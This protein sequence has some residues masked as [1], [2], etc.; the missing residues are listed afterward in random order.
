M[1]R[2]YLSS[3]YADLV[4]PR[5]GVYRA[6]RRLGHDVIAMEDYGA[7]DER[8]A[9]KCV[10]DAA[11]ADIYVGI[12]AWRYGYLPPGETRS[13]TELEFRAAR[14]AGK[15]CLL[16]LLHEDAPWPRSLVDRN[17]EAIE[18]LRAE[19][20]RDFT[21]A[22]FRS[23]DDLAARVVE[24][25]AALDR[26]AASPRVP[27]SSYL[28]TPSL[29]IEIWQEDRRNPLLREEGGVIRVPMKHAPFEMRI[30]CA[31]QNGHVKVAAS[32]TRDL[33]RFVEGAL[34]RDEVP[35]FGPGTGMADTSFGSGELWMADDAHMYLDWG[36]RLMPQ[37]GG[38]G[39][40]LFN[41]IG[42]PGQAE[43]LPIGRDVF[44]VVHAV[45]GGDNRV[46][47]YNCERLILAF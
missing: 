32:F 12:F 36:G 38:G 1:A 13:I 26:A 6:L 39:V 10:A 35:F 44:M 41:S 46:T 20:T 14:A 22:F 16:F 40:V 43:E 30:A 29:G 47:Q 15:T 25:V 28:R 33:F 42:P 2:I 9:A 18:N 17:E 8:P 23:A 45:A 11:A 37:P 7:S 19:L 4:T 27:A 21:V 34:T 3:T 31:E 5:E 24:S